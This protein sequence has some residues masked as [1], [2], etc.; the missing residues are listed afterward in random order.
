M[1]FRRFFYKTAFLVTFF[2]LS[3]GLWH[4]TALAVNEVYTV[5]GISVDATADTVIEAKKAALSQGYEKA[6]LALIRKLVPE[7]DHA[8]VPKL[9]SKDA[10]NYVLDISLSAERSSSVR[11]IANMTVRFKESQTRGLLRNSGAAIAETVSKPVLII[12]IEKRADSSLLWED[13]NQW[14]TAWGGVGASNGLVPLT[15]PLGDLD[16]LALVD[17]KGALAGNEGL[18]KLAGKYGSSDVFLSVAEIT[19]D[20]A[21][22]NLSA[23]RVGRFGEGRRYQLNVTKAEGETTQKM[24]RRAARSLDNSLQHDWKQANLLQFGVERWIQVEVPISGLQDWVLVNNRLQGVPAINKVKTRS[25]N[26]SQVNL[27]VYFAGDER[28]LSLAL[29]QKDLALVLNE[30]SIWELQILNRPKV[31]QGLNLPGQTNNQVL[32]TEE[33]VVDEVIVPEQEIDLGPETE[34]VQ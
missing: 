3:T 18:W 15:M 22:A 27:D 4:S 34:V 10:L 33:T 11:Y 28:Q 26:R 29:A 19:N 7:H 21:A 31:Q 5:H 20:G 8:K 2:A 23:V 1:R 16:D 14:R 9:N 24:L 17:A 12:P 32:A 30:R 6:F 13:R 25:I